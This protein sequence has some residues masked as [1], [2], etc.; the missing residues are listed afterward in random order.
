MRWAMLVV[1]AVGLLGG[2][3]ACSGINASGSVSPASFFLPGLIQVTP[4]TNALPPASDS[5]VAGELALLR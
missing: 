5:S 4:P 2:L 3:T 1:L